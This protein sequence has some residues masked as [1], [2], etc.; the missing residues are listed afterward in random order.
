MEI[1]KSNLKLTFLFI[2]FS[3]LNKT[4]KTQT[5]SKKTMEDINKSRL[6]VNIKSLQINSLLSNNIFPQY[7]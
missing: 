2:F 6:N 1:I 5:K 4:N 7:L 3:D